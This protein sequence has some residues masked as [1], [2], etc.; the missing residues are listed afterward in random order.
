MSIIW[1]QELTSRIPYWSYRPVYFLKPKTE[2]LLF[3]VMIFISGAVSA[4]D[5]VLNFLTRDEL[6]AYEIN[7]VA[8]LII[9][10]Y[11][12]EG[13]ICIKAVSTGL[14]IAALVALLYLKPKYR[15]II[16]GVFLFQ[17]GLFCFLSFYTG[18]G[19][20]RSRDMFICVEMAIE[21]YW[22]LY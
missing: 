8:L 9:N 13:L 6:Q 18:R 2:R 11:G 22:G 4:Y 14:A 16:F 5:N 15:I 12:V 1:G 3:L 19:I 20:F 21:F 10:N 7:P 17:C